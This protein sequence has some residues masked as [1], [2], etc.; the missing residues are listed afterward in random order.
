MDQIFHHNLACSQ[1]ERGTAGKKKH[2]K[3]DN[4]WRRNMNNSKSENN[5][6]FLAL[7]NKNE[8]ENVE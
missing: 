7:I 3:R 2:S 5:F 6:T 4:L 8:R 1:E